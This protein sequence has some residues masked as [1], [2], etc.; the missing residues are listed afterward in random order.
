[1]IWVDKEDWNDI[2][3]DFAA[4]TLAAPIG[5]G[6][7]TITLT[8]SADFTDT[9]TIMVGANSYGYSA[10]NRGTGVL[11]IGAST[12][13]NAVGTDVF[14][15]AFTGNPLYWTTYGGVIYHWPITN[16]VYSGRNYYMDYYKKLVQIY[17]DA[18]EI[19]L[20]DP[21]IVQYYC[22]WKALL[23]IANGEQTPAA[24]GMYEQYLLRR[25][26]AKQ[27]ESLNREFY[28][29]PDEDYL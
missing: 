12:T 3:G 29:L 21:T 11:T 15:N 13:T 10:N 18:D 25:E 6:N 24:Q 19:V 7:V 20:P 2:V 22:A 23:K 17:T 1:M 5:L 4:T 26:K 16:S 8:S 28:L 14:Q 27:K 9:G